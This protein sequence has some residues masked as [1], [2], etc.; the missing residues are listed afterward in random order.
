MFGIRNQ[1]DIA[2]ILY[3]SM[4]KAPSSGKEGFALFARK[5]NGVERTLHTG[6]G[7]ACTAPQRIKFLEC[8]RILGVLK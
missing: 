8:V 2:G 7:A 3:Q 4:L 6:I 5:A 1:E